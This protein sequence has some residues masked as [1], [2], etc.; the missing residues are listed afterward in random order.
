MNRKE[1]D[2][3]FDK[4][5]GGL[6]ENFTIPRKKKPPQTTATSTSE[7]S[8]DK[9]SRAIA[10]TENDDSDMEHRAQNF[11][12]PR[13]KKQ[14]PSATST[15]E[16]SHDK[17]S[18]AETEEDDMAHAAQNFTRNGM[19][20]S[21]SPKKTSSYG[22]T[23]A[24]MDSDRL[25]RLIGNSDLGKDWKELKED[26]KRRKLESKDK[27][28]DE[29][30][31]HSGG[32][33]RSDEMSGLSHWIS[34]YDGEL[35]KSVLDKCRPA[36][37]DLCSVDLTSPIHAKSHYLGNPHKKET[38]RHLDKLRGEGQV[39]PSLKEEPKPLNPQLAG[40][41]TNENDQNWCKLCELQLSSP[42]VAMAHYNGKNHAKKAK[43]VASGT[44][45]PVAKGRGQEGPQSFGIGMSF[46]KS[47]SQGNFYKDEPK[48]ESTEA[49]PA[50][51]EDGEEAGGLTPPNNDEP[52]EEGELTDDVEEASKKDKWP[53]QQGPR[54]YFC[55]PCKCYFNRS[56][57]YSEH[58]AS[59]QHKT[60]TISQ[61]GE[62]E[63]YCSVC[64]A[65]CAT[66]A[67][68]EAHL[69]NPSHRRKVEE[70]AGPSLDSMMSQI[71]NDP[72]SVYFC[73]TCKVQCAGPQPYE[74]H[75][76]GK[77]HKSKAAAAAAGMSA[78]S[79]PTSGGAA[80][81]GPSQ[82]FCSLCNVSTT[83]Q[84]GLKTHMEGKKH[85]KKEKANRG[86]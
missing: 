32:S 53:D 21:P 14:Q 16:V 67:A 79:L 52:H 61:I 3:F 64:M 74:A 54:R 37:C 9:R 35:P 65:Q 48:T 28:W 41:M 2:A 8:L 10:E 20:K 7:P 23:P 36:R 57:E 76:A 39:V 27:T 56:W 12:S 4:L 66:K 19:E 62:R 34:C 78:A 73:N 22:R 59:G 85:L 43:A 44:Y 69:Q 75:L 68:F 84:N 29:R 86:C 83:D 46:Y 55:L 6:K 25:K 11:T 80:S 30:R 38:K 18:G 71:R 24:G 45:V 26:R 47:D 51:L 40:L 49:L 5:E 13:T 77:K 50:Q 15:S 31:S 1:A 72:K 81:G 63:F 42:M 82:F 33:Q 17:R 60:N 58:I 70:A